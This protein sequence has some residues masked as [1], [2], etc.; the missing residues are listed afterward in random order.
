MVLLIA[1][2]NIGS[3]LLVRGAAR[4]REFAIRL[5]TGASGQRLLRQLLTETLVIFALGA[6]AGVLVAHAAIQALLAF[7]AIGRNPVVPRRPLRLAAGSVRRSRHADRRAPHRAVAGAAG[8]SVAA[9]AGDE[10]D[11][12]SSR[13]CRSRG[14]CR[15]R[16][17]GR[18]GG[19]CRSC[20]W[21]ARSC[22][23][24]R[25]STCGQ[26]IWDSTGRQRVDD[27]GDARAE[28][29]AYRTSSRRERFWRKCWRA[30]GRC[31]ASQPP[32]SRC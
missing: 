1:C 8:A 3:L 28:A 18:A 5:A 12:R 9:A 23:S 6:A 25:W 7:F 24:E 2:A 22:S 11:R 13:W 16:A 15:A 20:C 4:A 10:G 27:V 32:A 31:P 26:S 29:R 30:C 21:S 17:R 19:A 14:T